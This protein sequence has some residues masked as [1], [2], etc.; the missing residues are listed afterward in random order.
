[1]IVIDNININNYKWIV[2]NKNKV[3]SV[4]VHDRVFQNIFHV[5]K[6]NLNDRKLII[7]YYQ[8]HLRPHKYLQTQ[9]VHFEPLAVTSAFKL[10]SV[11]R[12][13]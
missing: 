2:A 5:P 9:R 11:L 1:M 10:H 6:K 3:Q 7:N 4:R 8:S 12:I 13:K